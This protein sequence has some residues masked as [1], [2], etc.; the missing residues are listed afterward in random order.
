MNLSRKL[1]RP[2]VWVGCLIPGKVELNSEKRIIKSVSYGKLACHTLQVNV[3]TFAVL[4]KCLLYGD[5]G[6]RLRGRCH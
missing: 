4:V 5:C 3:A 1:N 6:F 2:N